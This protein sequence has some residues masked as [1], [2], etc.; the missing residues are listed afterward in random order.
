[1]N[2]GLYQLLKLEGV[3]VSALTPGTVQG[4]LTTLPV[5]TGLLDPASGKGSVGLEG[6]VEFRARQR[7]VTL[8]ELALDTTKHTLTGRLGGRKLPIAGAIGLTATREGFGASTAV[9]GLKLR[10]TAAKILN[11]KLGLDRVFRSGRSF[12]EASSSTQPGALTILGGS[13]VL[14]GAEAAFAKLKALEVE[15]TPFES[16]TVLSLKPP[17]FG[18][19]LLPSGAAVP[20]DLSGGGMG[21]E[22]GLRL[23]QQG[24]SP[25]AELSLVGLSV[26]LES[27]ILS[28]D[29][30]AETPS[31]GPRRF[32]V[33]PIA[34]LDTAGASTSTNPSTRTITLANATATIDQFLAENLNETFAKPKGK[35]PPFSP[36]EPLGTVTITVQTQ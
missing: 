21:S 10:P 13:I 9:K 4:R 20:L 27:K 36:G 34:T 23:I 3:H 24:G 22:T 30:S 14:T 16:A 17:T 25:A 1:M 28:A 18:F 33:T 7:R 2:R 26:S 8:T 31:A 5:G 29:T 12:A 6:G 19:P 11:R 15:A 32:G 35:A